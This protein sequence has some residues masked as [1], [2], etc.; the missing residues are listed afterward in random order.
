[1]TH[2]R[3]AL[4]TS[5]YSLMR[6]GREEVLDLLSAAEWLLMPV[7][8]LGELEGAFELGSRGSANR[9]SLSEFLAEPFVSVLSITPEV[10][11]RYGRLFAQQRRAGRPVP[12]NDLWIAATAIDA[13]AHLVTS[14]QDFG[15]IAGLDCTVLEVG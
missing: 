2:A 15:R 11:R 6:S 8:V 12:V 9:L 13:G 4:D 5:A 10:A 7:V 3:L 1:M 14:D